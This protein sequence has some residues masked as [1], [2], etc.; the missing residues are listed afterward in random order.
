M[1]GLRLTA[2]PA[3]RGV[4]LGALVVL[5][6]VLIGLALLTSAMPL[7]Y[8]AMLLAFAAAGLGL[9]RRMARVTSATLILDDEALYEEGGAMLCRVADIAAVERGPF[10]FKPSNGFLIR[11]K[12]RHDRVWRP[13]LWWRFGK[14]LGVG[15]VTPAAEGKAM[16]DVLAA[17]V[18]GV[19]RLD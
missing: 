16:A 6:V 9:A 11:L 13:G 4:A 19:G 17:R 5:G 2:S 18:A 7:G 10:A 3:R 8:R 14:S 12:T 15:G 1:T